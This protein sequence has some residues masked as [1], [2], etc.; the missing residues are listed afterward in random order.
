MRNTAIN[1]LRLDVDQK[2]TE[3]MIRKKIKELKRRE[4][5]QIE[6]SNIQLLFQ[7]LASAG[8]EEED[9]TENVEEE[10]EDEE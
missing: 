6:F 9:D 8:V 3:D 2:P 7:S 5:N 1:A 4:V 10:E